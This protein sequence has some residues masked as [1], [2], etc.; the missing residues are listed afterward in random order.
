MLGGTVRVNGTDGVGSIW[1]GWSLPPLFLIIDLNWCHCFENWNFCNWCHCLEIWNFCPF[2]WFPWE[3]ILLCVCVYFVV[4]V[5]VCFR[6]LWRG[7]MLYFALSFLFPLVWG[8]FKETWW[9]LLHCLCCCQPTG[10]LCLTVVSTNARACIQ[11][12]SPLT[13][14]ALPANSKHWFTTS[15]LPPLPYLV[16]S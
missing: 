6:I 7:L 2:V 15:F 3:I 10:L 13:H 14:T 1:D 9:C 16:T 4:V 12:F 5:F 11:V 8:Y